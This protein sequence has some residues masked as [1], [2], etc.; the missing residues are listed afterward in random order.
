MLNLNLKT[1]KG[2]VL[3]RRLWREGLK[4]FVKL[5]ALYTLNR[6]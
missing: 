1:R 4:L 2:R 5:I 3:T 6:F